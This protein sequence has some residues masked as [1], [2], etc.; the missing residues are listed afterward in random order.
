MKIICKNCGWSWNK[1]DGGVNPCK[2]H[3][4]GYNNMYGKKIVGLGGVGL[5]PTDKDFNKYAIKAI[6]VIKSGNY[7]KSEDILGVTEMYAMDMAVKFN[8][9]TGKKYQTSYKKYKTILLKKVKDIL[10]K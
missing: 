5:K 9:S 6:K 10:K 7:T 3:K 2:C 1:K 8:G 4:C